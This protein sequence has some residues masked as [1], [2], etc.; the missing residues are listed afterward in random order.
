ML[1]VTQCAQAASVTDFLELIR[2]VITVDDTVKQYFSD[3]QL[4]DLAERREQL[5]E[6]TI[7]DAQARW[8]DLITRVQAA[9]DAQTDPATPE[10]QQL[11]REWMDLLRQLHGG[12]AGIRDSLYRRQA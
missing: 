5:G 3:T 2:K 10:A 9:I 11:A 4:A 7:A 8:P 1:T 12:D 6:K